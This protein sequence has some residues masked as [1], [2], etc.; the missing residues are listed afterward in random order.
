MISTGIT[1]DMPSKDS[2]VGSVSK[3]P[4]IEDSKSTIPGVAETN[5]INITNSDAIK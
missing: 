2:I 4:E 1:I 5:R 3:S